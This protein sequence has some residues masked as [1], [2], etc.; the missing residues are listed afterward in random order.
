MKKTWFITGASN[1]FGLSLVRQLLEQG[2][3]VAATSR[4]K[5]SIEE[6]T[7]RHPNLLA[8]T[9]DITSNS[10]VKSAIEKTVKKF[11]KIDIA[12]NNAGY[13]LLGALEEVSSKEFQESVAVNLFAFQNVIHSVMPYFRKQES[14][15]IFNFASSAGYSADAGAGS[16]NAVK[17]AIIGL[18]EALSKEVAQ[19]N[20]K[21]TIVS[22]GLFRTN[23]LGA[24]PIAQNKIEAYGT[25]HLIDTMNQYNGQQPGDP[26]KL[27]K[28][29]IDTA[30]KEDAPLHLLMGGDAYERAITYYKSQI[31]NLEQLKALSFSTNFE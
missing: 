16:Y 24:F 5:I 27:V 10:D 8:L 22:P 15:H 20:V 11:G 6:K 18:S 21:V 2:H 3:Q 9:V 23:F 12:V 13:M 1:G 26:D 19:F 31:E 7:G 29:L 14:G 4:N 28:V 25:K 17:S 30:G